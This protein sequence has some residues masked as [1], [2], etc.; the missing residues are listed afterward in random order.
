MGDLPILEVRDVKKAFGGVTAV[1]G[2]SFA[3]RSSGVH[4]LIGPNGA[5]KTTL[6]NLIGGIYVPDSG[7]ITIAGTDVSGWG[8]HKLAAQGVSRTFQNLRIFTEMTAIEN[9]MI[10]AHLRL[11]S[12][13]F[14]GMLRLPSLRRRDSEAESE[15][16]QLL[17]FV[18][19]ATFADR[20]AAHLPFGALKR[21]EIARALMARS[22]LLLLDE[23]GA[24]LNQ[25]EK[26]QLQTLIRTVADRGIN[27]F[28]VEHDMKLVMNISDHIIVLA[29]GCKLAEGKSTEIRENP[30]VIA[31]YLGRP[32]E[33]AKVDA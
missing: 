15:A 11:E 1:N 20:V 21:L 4:S 33:R 25:G 8:P 31:A 6:F 2:V 24:G 28:L 32:V 5:G 16:R 22:R 3:I 10:G 19:I 30:E 27:V 29:N 7:S 9:V 17:E 14:A 18:G 13:I 26:A 23:P 12:R